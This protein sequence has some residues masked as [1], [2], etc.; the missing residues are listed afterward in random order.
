MSWKR[1]S[2][3]K[4]FECPYFSV[5][6]DRVITH[7]NK[8][9][10]YFSWDIPDASI[11]I[12][13]TKNKKIVFIRQYRYQVDEYTLELPCGAIE[14]KETALI[15][16]KKELHEE[17]GITTRSCKKVGEFYPYLGRA[18]RV[19]HVFIAK[20]IL[21]TKNN[22]EET[23]EITGIVQVPITKISDMIEKREI[24]DGLTLSALSLFFAGRYDEK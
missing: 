7:V 4:V 13:V 19:C 23:E 16:A 21:T 2:R 18:N 24:K 22:P 11:I 5:L 1:K 20:D 8:E 10:D 12:P 17:A 3:K 15:T 6:H 9:I 14:K